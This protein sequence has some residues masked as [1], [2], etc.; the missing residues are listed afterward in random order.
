MDS[1]YFGDSG[2]VDKEII[3]QSEKS[4]R[5]TDD[6]I[7]W[8]NYI[9]KD[10][11]FCFFKDNHSINN[12]KICLSKN[13]FEFEINKKKI[14]E[15][16]SFWYRRGMH[17][18]NSNNTELKSKLHSSTILPIIKF[19]EKSSFLNKINKF[20][21]NDL[22]KLDTLYQCKKLGIN[23]PQTIITNRKEDLLEFFESSNVIINKPLENPF[24][25]FEIL[26]TKIQFSTSTVLIR[27]EEVLN[28]DNITFLPS[29]F[30]EYIEK[31]YEI[32]SF[33]LNG[34][35]KSMAIFSQ[36]NEKTKIDYRNYDYTRPNRY[37]P[38]KLPLWYE[39]KIDKLMKR[40]DINSGSIDIIYSI[41]GKYYFLE[42]NPVGQFQW[43]SRNCNYYIEKQIAETLIQNAS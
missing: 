11:N 17:S 26:N 25:N 15:S 3:I 21:D 9:D 10:V 38:F 22:L 29:L 41:S 33:Y 42:V 5:S 24:L 18:I 4:D 19:I 34:S 8:I 30:Q 16:E 23:F 20:E 37:V 6:V 35:F 43:L 12:L 2:I 7:S 32:R 28:M 36:Q 40:L 14:K 1:N 27:K 31:K 39:K 13:N